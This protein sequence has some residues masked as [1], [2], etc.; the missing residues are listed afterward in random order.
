MGLDSLRAPLGAENLSEVALERP[1]PSFLQI[2][3]L[4]P[5]VGNL[6]DSTDG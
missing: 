1:F 6:L 3:N 5:G 4:N 2:W